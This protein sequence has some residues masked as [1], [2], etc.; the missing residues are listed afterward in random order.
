MHS[1]FVATILHSSIAQFSS[2][3]KQSNCFLFL[4]SYDMSELEQLEIEQ[5]PIYR[6][7][8]QAFNTGNQELVANPYRTK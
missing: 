1:S 2:F 4:T 5:P 8:I 6:R 7:V 3:E